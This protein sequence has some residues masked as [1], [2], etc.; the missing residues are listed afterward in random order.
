LA[1]VPRS[2]VIPC[3]VP[4]VDRQGSLVVGRLSDVDHRR[5]HVTVVVVIVVV[6]VTAV[7]VVVQIFGELPR[8]I[9]QI[10]RWQQ[11]PHTREGPLLRR[12][13]GDESDGLAH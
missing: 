13:L 7:A 11:L 4:Q 2:V 9:L 3:H 8:C 5:G 6:V 12:E 1:V 10:H